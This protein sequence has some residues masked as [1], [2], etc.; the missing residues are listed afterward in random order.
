MHERTQRAIARLMFV[1]CCAIPT[2]FTVF[3][4]LVT[5][6]PWYHSRTVHRLEQE[7]ADSTGL[8]VSLDDVQRTAP[9]VW[10]LLGMQLIDPETNGEVARV[11]K[12]EWSL[13]NN[14]AS[15]LLHQPELE[16]RY[17]AQ[18]WRLI[19]DRWIIRPQASEKTLTVACND[20]TIHSQFGS[21]TLR[22]VDAWIR[23]EEKGVEATIQ[24][25]PASSVADAPLQMTVRRD[26]S[27]ERPF[28]QWTLQTG[29]TSLPCSTLAEYVPWMA[30]LG[31]QATF[32]GTMAWQSDERQW[33]MDLGG[34]RFENVSLDRFFEKHAHRLSGSA[35]VVLDRCRIDPHERRSDISGSIRVQDGAIGR[36]LLISAQENLGMQ[37][38]LPNHINTAP[39][40]IPFDRIAIGFNINNTQMVLGGICRNERGF[41]SYPAGVVM[42]LDG[43]PIATTNDAVLPAL[44]LLTTI[45]PSHSVAVP[46]SSQTQ[47]MLNIFIPPSRPMPTGQ[48]YPPRIRSAR[49][50]D[51]GPTISQ[52]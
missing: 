5:W 30:S 15:L 14:E 10:Q 51:A 49:N 22:D 42:L 21:M 18:A 1:F 40:D 23:P 44:K 31:N 35:D 36:S 37:V 48:D 20:L 24:G 50:W 16:S 41:E 29:D 25:L 33:S 46:V 9:G 2:S 19:H 3:C 7:L 11:R 38:R 45:A 26:R 43:Y 32:S 17:L 6:T 27:R 52:P 4:I 13:R 39:G 8:V 34:S 47:S 12:V 28:T